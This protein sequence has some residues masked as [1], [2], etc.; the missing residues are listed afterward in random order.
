MF[1][2][3]KIHMIGIGGV[4]MS[5]IADILLSYNCEITG[6]DAK[7]SDL[8][9]RLIEKGVKVSYEINLENVDNADIIIYTAAIKDD[10][11]ELAYAK[12]QKK[13]LYE[14]SVFFGLMMKNYKNVLCISGTHGKS[15]TSGMVSSIFLEA[16]LN[17]TIQ[18]GAI[19][20]KIQ[21]ND[22]VGDK[23]YF[24]AEACEYVDSFLDFFPTAE[25]ILN[26]DN[27]HLDY[28]GNLDNIIHSFN[29]YT[30]L[31]P[32]NG[33]LVI[34]A[35]DENTLI[36]TRD[37]NKKI[38]Y[39]LENTANYMAKN[40]N[41]NE[42]GH[43]NYDLYI[44]NEMITTVELSVSGYHNV[45]NSLAA[46]ALSHQYISDLEIIKKAL[47]EY[48]GVGRRFELLGSYNECSVYDDYAHHPSEI[49][50][51]YESVKKTKHNE[52]WAIFQPH[53]YSR[54]KDHLKEFAEV[55]ANFDHIVIAE[56]YAAREE[57]IYN[58]HS[59]DIVKLIK[60]KG[61]N[62]VVYIDTFDKIENYIRE[63]VQPGDLI[64]TIGA[65]P[66]NE[67]AKALVK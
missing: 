51:T 10:N 24:I 63:N 39:G 5:G 58:V 20:P 30:K 32:E 25:I 13:E 26:I 19:L 16:E 40:I 31:L 41:F 14:R 12:K 66:V 3:K 50:T 6:Y 49:K 34:N 54:T 29:R 23:E 22:F 48:R 27:D 36:A 65:G 53:T 61:N 33:I 38:T 60:E 7:E 28:F 43:P 35:D 55:L 45:Y 67:V 1:T 59:E 44:N 56:I 4:S 64:I 18:I 46:I 42:F 9:K 47:K 37:V 8:T 62:N 2:N 15:T 21:G 52:N 11:D 17:P 57:N